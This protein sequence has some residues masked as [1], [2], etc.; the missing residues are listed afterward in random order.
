MIPNL[1]WFFQMRCPKCNTL[2]SE[3]KVVSS[4]GR[5]W[6]ATMLC[7]NCLHRFTTKSSNPNWKPFEPPKG[8]KSRTNNQWDEEE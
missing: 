6:I 2:M 7:P 8:G 3:N 5:F 4:C 1:T